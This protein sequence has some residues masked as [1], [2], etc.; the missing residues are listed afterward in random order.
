MKFF[1]KY[2][3]FLNKCHTID[4]MKTVTEAVR[5][6]LF[7]SDVALEALCAG[8]LNMS[9]FAEQIKPEVERM[10]WKSAQKNTVVVALSRVADE[11]DAVPALHLEV[12]IDELS[13][14]APLA[15]ITYERTETT[16]QSAQQLS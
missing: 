12:L 13:M 4:I 1:D 15:D 11:L 8:V 3:F 2:V 10:T 16:L 9:A 5:E 6:V 14:K 7:T